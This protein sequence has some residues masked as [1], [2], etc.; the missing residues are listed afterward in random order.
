LDINGTVKIDHAAVP[1]VFKE[2]AQSVTAGG[3]WR[4]PLDNGSLRFD[5]STNADGNFFTFNT[6]LAMTSNGDVGIGTM[7][8]DARLRISGGS[9]KLDATATISAPGRLHIQAENENL[10]LNPWSGT[11]F[12]GYGGGPGNL[13]VA[14]TLSASAK[15]FQIDHPLDPDKKLLVHSSLE[16]PE[17]AVYYRG[18]AQ[19]ENGEVTITLP[20]YFEA[21]SRKEQRTVQLT[22]VKGWSPLYVVEDIKDG[23]FAVRSAGGGNGMQRFYWEVKAVRAD[24]AP[25]V[26]EK[27]KADKDINIAQ[28]PIAAGQ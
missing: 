9:L 6:P 7:S 20:S 13:Y 12:V 15:S 11:T 5:V 21:L 19:L 23:R 16:G 17:V 10:Y 24:V 3:L 27:E 4:M 26:V 2:T 1:L 14:G 25:L 8:P 18:E 28:S 22:S